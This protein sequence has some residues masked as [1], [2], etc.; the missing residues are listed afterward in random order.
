MRIHHR[1][2]P[3]RASSRQA[4]S[5]VEIL[6]ALA[7]LTFGLL[8]MLAVLQRTLQ[9]SEPIEFEPRAAMLADSI[10]DAIRSHPQ[11]GLPWIPGLSPS[12][13]PVLLQGD[14]P[15]PEGLLL[16]KDGSPYRLKNTIVFSLPGNGVDD[17][18][19]S[20]RTLNPNN[21][22]FWKDR[23]KFFHSVQSFNDGVDGI[24]D[25]MLQLML[26]MLARDINGKA[27]PLASSGLRDFDGVAEQDV[28]QALLVAGLPQGITPDTDNDGIPDDTG[29]SSIFTN[30][31]VYNALFGYSPLAAYRPDGDFAYDPQRGIDEEISNGRDDDGDGLT[32]EDLCLASQ[33]RVGGN[34]GNPYHLRPL[35]P[36][37]GL[38]D[39]GDGE[40]GSPVDPVTG[41]KMADGIDNDGNGKIDEGIDEE[42]YDGMDNDGD[43]R[44]DEDCQ[45]AAV[46][47]QPLP[48]PYPND[49]Y[50]FRVTVRRVPLGGDGV[51][52][53]G[54][55]AL[56]RGIPGFD[57][58]DDGAVDEADES[59]VDEEF[60]DGA[61]NDGDGLTDEDLRAYPAPLGRLVTVYVFQGGD[62]KDNDGDGWIDEEALDGIDNDFDGKIDED[63]YRRVYK[64][65]AVIQLPEE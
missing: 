36:G 43:G 33:V 11:G 64:T 46:P 28:S 22:L 57:D 49:E 39:D 30:P 12:T 53:D 44:I 21:P 48:F 17:D 63:T 10:L 34:P 25:I 4:F 61:D 26:P 65:S 19:F 32:D 59:A 50:S 3:S 40:K 7:V 15:Y 56:R 24:D 18:R 38:D 6:A 2:F 16:N 58:D 55:A 51:D 54:D 41:K 62:R 8:G 60:F 5:L 20:D 47:W 9:K 45:A 13:W 23:Q 14:N 52:S 29:D 42:I 31:N 1:L 27:L 37:N 35:L